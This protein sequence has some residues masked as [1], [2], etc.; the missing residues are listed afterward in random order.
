MADGRAD[1]LDSLRSVLDD[2]VEH[3]VLRPRERGLRCDGAVAL[4]LLGIQTF[5]PQPS[6]VVN[7]RRSLTSLSFSG[8]SVMSHG[9][10]SQVRAIRDEGMVPMSDPEQ[11]A[12]YGR[13]RGRQVLG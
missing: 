7:V 12:I 9:A 3:E 5:R 10:Q 11:E 8:G 2:K 4:I 6:P 1:L 13:T